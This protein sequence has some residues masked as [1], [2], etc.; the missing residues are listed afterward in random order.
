MKENV[1]RNWLGWSMGVVEGRRDKG[2][3]ENPRNRGTVLPMRSG[4][5][6]KY[7]PPCRPMLMNSD[8][9]VS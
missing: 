5:T 8:S 3:E 9:K 7:L 6:E 2:L 4:R 1:Q